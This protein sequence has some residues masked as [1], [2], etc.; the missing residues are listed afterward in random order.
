MTDVDI[1][2]QPLLSVIIPAYNSQDY[3]RRCVESLIGYAHPIEILIIDDGSSDKTPELADKL[4]RRFPE[5]RAVHQANAGH[6]GALNTGIREATGRYLKVVDSDD[7]LD[8]RS[9]TRVLDQMAADQDRG[10]DVDMYVANYVYEKQGKSHKHAVRFLNVLPADRIIGWDDMRA[11]RYDQYLMMHT[12]IFRTELVRQSGM[13][14]PEHTFYVDYLYSYV[15]LPHVRT[16]RYIDANLYRYFIGRDDQSVNE[17]VMISRIDQLLRV[18][19]GMLA[20]TPDESTVPAHLYRYMIHYLR[21]NFI[22]CSLMLLLSGTP[23]HVQEKERLWAE[24]D[25][26]Y[27]QVTRQVRSGLLGRL[28]SLPGTPGRVIPLSIYRIARAVLG[29]N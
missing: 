24:A 25:R 6:G 16:L 10:D 12:L 27:P 28:I 11:C 1:S 7:W 2:H 21:I 19:A 14:L 5:F 4:A 26:D 15:P 18:N 23:E 13:I 29:F 17:K 20:G 22:V 8:R 9:L 3:L